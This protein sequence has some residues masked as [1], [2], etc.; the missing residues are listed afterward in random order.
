MVEALLVRREKAQRVREDL[1]SRGIEFYEERDSFHFLFIF[2][3]KI[4]YSTSSGKSCYLVGNSV[5]EVPTH[6]STFK[7]EGSREAI[8]AFA[9][10]F[11]KRGLKARME[12]PDNLIEIRRWDG[13]YLVS[14]S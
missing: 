4:G 10:L 8:R 7:I 6:G 11:E 9:S 5:E 13:K 14:V 1:I 2:P 12:D 3:S